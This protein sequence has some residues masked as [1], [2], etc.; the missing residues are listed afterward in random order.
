MLSIVSGSSIRM[1]MRMTS[2]G[3]SL[4]VIRS[5]E[6]DNTERWR[7]VLGASSV[8]RGPAVDIGGCKG[9]FK[10]EKKVMCILTDAGGT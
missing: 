1:I 5:S 2:V 4:R 6:E 10:L 8:P 9:E 7:R 3:K